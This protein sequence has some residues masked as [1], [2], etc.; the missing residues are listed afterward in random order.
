MVIATLVVGVGGGIAGAVV[1]LA[2][3][4]IEHAA[5][6]YNVGTFLDGVTHASPIQRVISLVVA[7]IIG[8]VGWW[9]LRRWGRPVV[10]VADTVAG[11]R[12][13]AVVT[14][15]NVGLQVVIVG[16]GA[17][18]GREVA[19]RE[20]G[21]LI[22]GW[23]GARARLSP[24]QR[25]MLVACGAGSALAAVYNVPLGGALFS[26]EVLLVEW[27]LDVVVVAVTTSVVATVVA[28]VVV[29]TSPL[30]RVPSVHLSGSLVVGAVVAGPFLGALAT[31]FVKLIAFAGRHRPRSFGVL[32]A[33][34][35]IFAAVGGVSIWFPEILGN[36]R[37]LGQTAFSDVPI[38][39]IAILAIAKT[40]ATAGTIGSGAAGGT[41]TPALAVGACLGAA[42]GGVWSMLWPGSPVVAFALVGAAAF[43]GTTLSAPITAMVL[44]LEFTQQNTILLVPMMIATIGAYA[45]GRL[46]TR[47][48][49]A[50]ITGIP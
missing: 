8:A 21:A 20:L 2:L 39:L 26:I 38:V 25:R 5:F 4:G 9:A 1:S 37:A 36:G 17:S 16:L 27:S 14:I 50:R 40:L 30:Y 48:E 34:P 6:G 35:L 43:L 44:V 31:Y 22:A 11:S 41:L 7:G 42:F 10:S 3:H 46:L 33:M 29:P 15:A 12:M 49:T 13:P 18:I 28:W 23:V 19:P 45:V 32:I 47:R 24:R